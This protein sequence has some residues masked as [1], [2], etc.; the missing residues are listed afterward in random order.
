MIRGYFSKS[1]SSKINLPFAVIFLFVLVGLILFATSS[2]FIFQQIEEF[3]EQFEHVFLVN[4]IHAS[5]YNLILSAH[6]FLLT[7]EQSFVSEFNKNLGELTQHT[8]GYINMEKNKTYEEA[9][10]EI[11]LMQGIQQD[12]KSIRVT[13]DKLFRMFTSAGTVDTELMD[14]L[15]ALAYGI[16]LNV[17][18]VNDLHAHRS[19]QLTNTAKAR[20][21]FHGRLFLIFIVLGFVL[22]ILVNLIITRHVVR[23]VKKLAMATVDLA[24]GDLRRRV[25]FQSQ[26]EV[27]ALARSFNEMA[28]RLEAHDLEHHEF[29]MQ[30][31]E[32]VKERTRE[33]VRTTERLKA[34]QDRLISSEKQATIG[35]LAAGVTHEVRTPLNSLAINFQI[36][37]KQL[38]S[39]EELKSSSVA[40]TLSLI[41]MEVNRVNRVL[42]EFIAYAR[43]PE[44]EFMQMDIN[45]LVQEV[46]QFMTPKAAEN[47]VT[48]KVE[49]QHDLSRL[50]ADDEQVRQLLINL[51][52]NAIQAVPDGGSITLV[53]ELRQGV[54]GLGDGVGIRVSDE[55]SG[56]PQDV[57]EVIFEPFF[58]TKPDG[59][60]LGLAIVARI[61]EQH[62][63]HISCQSTVG[64]GTTFDIFLPFAHA[65]TN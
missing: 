59:L 61:V 50:E 42:E 25:S 34:T 33:L 16:E 7:K 32:M 23:P 39:F 53:T 51:C 55:G 49:L 54:A 11:T 43:F 62:N 28:E 2:R 35:R 26:D 20:I 30:L 40:E 9:A 64:R 56:I 29:S 18:R 44:P 4:Q 13:S 3:N 63:G 14:R 10:Q 5:S 8:T 27:G 48:F 12:I 22:L 57:M 17:K 6:H 24:K 46:A 52:A 38:Q 1:I 58:S 60:G 15:E 21:V 47:G 45:A 31:E 65:D 36:L 41:D 37:R 19:A